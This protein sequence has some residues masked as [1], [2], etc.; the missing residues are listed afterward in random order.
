MH[1]KAMDLNEQRDCNKVSPYSSDY[2]DLD[3]FDNVDD[4]RS[5][6]EIEYNS[7]PV[8]LYFKAFNE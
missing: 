2:Y 8:E 4:L 5:Y 1:N 3:N 6:L 7:F